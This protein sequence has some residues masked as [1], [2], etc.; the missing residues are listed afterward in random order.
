[1]KINI[2]DQ[3]TGNSIIVFT[4]LESNCFLL[5]DNIELAV[6]RVPRNIIDF[7]DKRVRENEAVIHTQQ[8]EKYHLKTAKIIDKKQYIN[9]NC[10]E[11]PELNI[12]YYVEILN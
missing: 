7:L 11:E 9:F 2:I 10:L 8:V 12:D 1:M 6:K 5:G 4:K 3:K